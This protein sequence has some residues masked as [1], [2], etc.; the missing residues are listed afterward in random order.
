MEAVDQGATYYRNY[1]C[2]Q[3]VWV[4]TAV[5]PTSMVMRGGWAGEYGPCSVPSVL[6]KVIVHMFCLLV[7][8]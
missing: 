8:S 7:F 6:Y 1:F 4:S 2:G 3:G 5:C